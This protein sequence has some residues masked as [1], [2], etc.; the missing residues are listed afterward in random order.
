[1][2]RFL[3]GWCIICLSTPSFAGGADNNSQGCKTLI[4]EVTN[5]EIKFLSKLSKD[6]L[7][8]FRKNDFSKV[9]KAKYYRYSQK[10][11]PVKK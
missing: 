7:S 4:A 11:C 10:S 8:Y 5:G 2:S 6:E 9:I 1:M 3:I